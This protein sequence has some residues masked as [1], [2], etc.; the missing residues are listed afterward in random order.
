MS[1]S[2]NEEYY[3]AKHEAEQDDRQVVEE[4][5]KKLCAVCGKEWPHTTCNLLG[6]KTQLFNSIAQPIV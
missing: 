4:G 2:H 6:A 1:N 5:Y 3:E